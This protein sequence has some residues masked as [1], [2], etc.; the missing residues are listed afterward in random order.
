MSCSKSEEWLLNFLTCW[1]TT[2]FL[3]RFSSRVYE[4]IKIISRQSI[5]FL[6]KDFQPTKMQIKPKPTNKNTNKRIKNNKGNN[7][8]R[9]KTS[10]RAKIGYFALCYMLYPQNFFL[11]KNKLVWS[12]LDSLIYSTTMLVNILKQTI[13]QAFSKYFV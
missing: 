2:K 13:R 3:T 7:L 1:K 12:C 11:K 10:K 9:I 5:C 4:A 8:S 6:R